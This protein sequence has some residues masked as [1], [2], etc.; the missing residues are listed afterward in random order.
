MEKIERK[1][2]KL[3]QKIETEA[4][5]IDKEKVLNAAS[6]ATTRDFSVSFENLRKMG[7]F[8]Y[9]YCHSLKFC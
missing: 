3:F 9:L 5:V 6:N 8:L 4:Y 2:A 1:R 7:I